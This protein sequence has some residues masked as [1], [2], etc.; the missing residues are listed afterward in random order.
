MLTDRGANMFA[1]SIG[2]GTVPTD[3]LVTEY[4]R[5]EWEKHKK[6]LTGVME[7]FNSQW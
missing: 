6:Y 2:T 7:D 3:S 4:E 1:E 5:R